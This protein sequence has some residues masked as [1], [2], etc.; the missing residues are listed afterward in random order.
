MQE[1]CNTAALP[2]DT[3]PLVRKI[4]C[5]E[6]PAIR[7]KTHTRVGMGVRDEME[8]DFAVKTRN[9]PPMGP[10][11]GQEH[12]RMEHGGNGFWLAAVTTAGAPHPMLE[13]CTETGFI[14][15]QPSM[16]EFMTALPQLGGGELSPQ[17]TPPGYA[18]DL[19]SPGGG[20]NVPEYPWM[21]EKKTTRKSSQ[22][23]N[24]LPR[25]LR[26]A[27]TNTQLLELEKEF[28]FNKYLCRPRR[29]EIAASL[30]LT[31]RQVKVWFQN[32]RMK[33]KRQTLSKTEDGD[34]K[35]STTSE[36]GKSSKTG[37]DKF[38]DDDGPLSGKKSC[39]GCEL[40]PGALCSPAEDLPE[41]ASRT[42]NNNTPSATNNNSF[43]SDGASSVASSSSLDKLAEDDSRDGHPPVTAMN[44][45]PRNLTKRIKQESRKRSPSLDATCKVSPSS[46]KDG[47]GPV[48]GLADGGKFSS[49]N[50]TPSSTPGTPSSM[51]QSPLGHYPRPSP[52]NAPPGPPHPQAV[53][54]AMPPYVI[55]GNAPPGQFVPHPDFRMDSK[56]F[57][58]KLTQYPQGNR[59]YEAYGA[60]IQSAEQHGYVR[61]QHHTRQE[62]SPSTRPTNGVGSR[63]AYPHEMYQNYGYPAYGKDQVAYGH[64]GYDQTQ[65]YSS[66]HMGYANSHY[67]YHYHEGTQHDHGHNYYAGEGQKNTHATDYTKNYY[68][69]TAYSQQAAYVASG[70]QAGAATA[71]GAGGAAGEAYAGADCGDGYGS[72]QQFYEATH[73]AP[74]GDNSNSSSDFHFLSNLA[75]DFA[76]E[77]YTI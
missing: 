21:K 37:L 49:V 75:N 51:H 63:Q 12:P 24:G 45:A 54:N 31:E 57:I 43:A 25:R 32:R 19:P 29:I 52:P 36:G 1:I 40:P 73:A 6:F 15:S 48:P 65:G 23:E 14:N 71:A 69:G 59:N 67:G 20:L 10:A 11:P 34:D 35:D 41:L 47:L 50:L 5:E 42:R 68:D 16:A 56:Q 70:A 33:H 61:N 7:G 8:E 74:P 26:T 28:H 62:G 22:Q 66:E 17:H 27:Y 72:F 30:D 39:Q 64:P 13:T 4:K 46:S 53:P 44:A 58:G 60:A 2:L 9:T 38:L 3:N 76:P 18:P 55:R 77:Y